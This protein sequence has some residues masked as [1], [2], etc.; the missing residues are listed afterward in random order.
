MA[1]RREHI[2]RLVKSGAKLVVID[3]R[4]IGVTKMADLWIKPR[5][6]SDYA[7]VFGLLK[8]IVEENLYDKGFVDKWAVG[9]DR[10]REHL[11]TFTLDEVEKITWIPRQQIEQLARWYSELVPS[12]VQIGMG[13]FGQG[14]R[15]FQGQ[16]LLDI[17]QAVVSPLNLPGWGIS[18]T[19]PNYTRA[20]RMYLLDKFPRNV[21]T[22]LA[23]KHKYALRAAYIPDQALINGILEDKIKAVLFTQC[24]PFMSAPNSRKAYDAFMKLDLLVSANIFMVPT[25]AMADI[26]LP[27]ATTN[28]CDTVAC[29]TGTGTLRAIPKIVDPP[30]EARSD[31]MILNDLGKRLGLGE[32][33]FD[34]D[35]ETMNYVLGPSGFTWED[36]KK[37]RMLAGTFEKKVEEEGYFTTTSGKAEIYSEQAMK[38]YGCSP[39]PLWE[40]VIPRWQPS[41]EYPLLMTSYMDE[42]F[43]LNKYKH[44]K[45]MRKRKTYPLV[46]LNPEIARSIGAVDGDWVWVESNMGRIMQKLAIDPEMDS[47][48]IMCNFGWYFPEDPSNADQWDKANINILIPDE[49]VEMASGAVDTRGYPCRVYKAEP[50][51]VCLPAYV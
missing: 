36:M 4:R 48:I 32:Y 34:S 39:M 21:E 37:K 38:T 46:R 49:P 14:A 20:G 2:K 22:N 15:S 47:R 1:A 30:G 44:V 33:F 45:S 31:V 43:H 51:E 40:E 27:V 3:P 9:F 6:T 28:E 8:V 41:E 19:R 16:R 10:L 13:S 12:I 42:E 17:L 35:A 18:A 23:K 7:L 29:F 5:P 11:K 24:D 50:S 25:A 26:V